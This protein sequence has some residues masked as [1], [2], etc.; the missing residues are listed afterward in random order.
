MRILWFPS[1]VE[2]FAALRAYIALDAPGR[3]DVVARR[4]LDAVERLAEFPQQGRVGRVSGT[5]ELVVPRTPYVVAYRVRDDVI[6]ILRV[7]H[8]ARRWPSP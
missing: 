1:A 2:D 7:L 6:Q 4:I 3:A 8:G 5:R